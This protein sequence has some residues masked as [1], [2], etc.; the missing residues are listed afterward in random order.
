M[1]KALYFTMLFSFLLPVTVSAQTNT[2]K[3]TPWE[4]GFLKL[5]T[6]LKDTEMGL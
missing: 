2:V 4:I 5:H 6:L 3:K 1:K